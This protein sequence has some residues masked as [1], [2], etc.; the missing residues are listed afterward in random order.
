MATVTAVCASPPWANPGMAS[1]DVALFALFRR[2]GIPADLRFVRLYT[3]GEWRSDYPFARQEPQDRRELLPFEYQPLRGEREALY[4]SSAI[5]F[6]GDFLHSYDYLQQVALTLTKIGASPNQAEALK[7]VFHYFYLDEAPDDVLGRSLAFGGT[8]IFN[9]ERD[10]QQPAYGY[11]LKR[12]VHRAHRVWMRDVYSA[13]RVTTL[14]GSQTFSLGVDCALL[15]RQEDLYLLPKT[16]WSPGE[17][18]A[19]MAGIFFGRTQFAPR[20]LARFARDL[21]RSL[22]ACAQWLPWFGSTFQPNHLPE[23]MAAFPELQVDE[24]PESPSTGDL[25]T[26]LAR[27]RF[28]VT[29]TYHVCLNAWRAGVPAICVGDASPSLHKYDVSD[30][31]SCAWRDKRYVFY[32]MLDAMEFYVFREELRNSVAYSN[33]LLYTTHLLEDRAVVE[34]IS[35]NVRARSDVAERELVGVLGDLLGAELNGDSQA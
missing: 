30:G 12:F 35:R 6:W 28:V 4:E 23:T 19:E 26:Q 25:L 33:R 27:Y 5:L 2:H 14:L 15:L 20:R 24:S 29:D 10:Y 11:Q 32:A 31:W 9:R 13:L 22:G 21:C 18:P 34:A 16:L 3:P 8:L 17:D 1:V 7:D